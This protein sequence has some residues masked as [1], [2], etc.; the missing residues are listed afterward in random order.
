MYLMVLV[1]VRVVIRLLLLISLL[2]GQ[3]NLLVREPLGVLQG[4]LLM[5]VAW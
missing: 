4:L 3:G 5:L 2:L 1:M